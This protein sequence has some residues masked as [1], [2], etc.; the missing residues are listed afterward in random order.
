[1]LSEMISQNVKLT[2]VEKTHGQN[3]PVGLID[4][5]KKFREK[6]KDIVEKGID[7][8]E[9]KEEF[10]G[11]EG[12]YIQFVKE[13]T[14]N[15]EERLLILLS[16]A[17][18][19][20]PLLFTEFKTKT[21]ELC[22]VQCTKTGLLL[23]TG[24]T[25]LKLV[26]GNSISKR[27]ET[28]G[29]LNTDHLF[30]RKSVIDLGEVCEGVANLFGVLKLTATYREIFLYNRHSK[31]RFSPEFPA[32][33]LETDLDWKDLVINPAT[34]ERLQE[35]KAFLDYSKPLREKWG[36]SKHMKQGYRCLF[37]GPSGTGKTLAAT[38][39]G[40]HV[41]REVYRVDMSSVISKYVGETSKNLNAL[42]NTAEDKDW[43]LFFDEGDALF[44]KRIDTSSADDK[45][46][47]FANQDIAFL[48]QRIENYNGLVIVASNFKKNMDDAFS[49]RF[50]SVVHF[51]LLEEELRKQ[52]WLDNIPANAKLGTGIDIALIAKRHPLSQASIINII[53]R[54]CLQTIKKDSTEIKSSDLELCIKD[55]LIK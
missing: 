22:L 36:L 15:K 42:F 23:P 41:N 16:L 24:E 54:V 21:N 26:S 32:H 11:S 5:F 1:M 3:F 40:K 52:Y 31:P 4:D 20:E 34:A 44:G 27:I 12:A 39:L 46:S 18:Y 33:P 14:L 2:V 19:L 49:R 29:I 38:L 47:H 50:L 55:E 37:Y 25:F 30:Y 13:N 45:N 10:H 43:I 51:D 28:H 53:T 35:I 8:F 48:L 7:A 17:Q 9:P 6:L